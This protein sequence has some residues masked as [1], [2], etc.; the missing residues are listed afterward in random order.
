M[1]TINIIFIVLG[2]LGL[3]H[4]NKINKTIV[5]ENKL[6]ELENE[7]LRGRYAYYKSHCLELLK[8]LRHSYSTTISKDQEI[9]E[10][11]KYAM[12]MSHPDNNGNAEDFMKFRKLYKEITE[13]KGN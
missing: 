2:T 11:V 6:L 3:I 5:R 4:M 13:R 12:K 8:E 7:R 9:I 10:A 1:T